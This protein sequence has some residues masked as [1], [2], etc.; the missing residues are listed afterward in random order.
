MKKITYEEFERGVS[1][2]PGDSIEVIKGGNCAF[3]LE[4]KDGKIV[5]GACKPDIEED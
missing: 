5:V 3:M 2:T 1:V 4:N